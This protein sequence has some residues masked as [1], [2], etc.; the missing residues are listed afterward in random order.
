MEIRYAVS[1]KPL[2]CI[3][4][5]LTVRKE[6]RISITLNVSTTLENTIIYKLSAKRRIIDSSKAKHIAA[7]LH[8]KYTQGELAF[9]IILINGKNNTL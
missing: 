6:I 4:T 8:T 5:I 1:S 7:T 2:I 3:G 9:M